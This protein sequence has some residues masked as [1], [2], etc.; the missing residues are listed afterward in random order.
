[1]GDLCYLQ[2]YLLGVVKLGFVKFLSSMNQ[3]TDALF[4]ILSLQYY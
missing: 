4:I 3:F 1:M 2:F